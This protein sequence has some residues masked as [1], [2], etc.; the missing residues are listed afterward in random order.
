MDDITRAVLA[1]PEVARYLQGGHGVTA[2]EARSKVMGFLGGMRT[3]QR[4]TLY[5]AINT[6]ST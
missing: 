1:R 3:T 5:K 4:Y 6:P 2:E